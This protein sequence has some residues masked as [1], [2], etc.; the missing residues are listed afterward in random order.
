[1]KNNF[2]NNFLWSKSGQLSNIYNLLYTLRAE[3]FL[4]YSHKSQN[5]FV[6]LLLNFYF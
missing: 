3:N 1:M 4:K 2:K 5:L 6:L